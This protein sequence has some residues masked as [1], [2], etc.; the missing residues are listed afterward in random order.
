MERIRARLSRLGL[1]G[2]GAIVAAALIPVFAFAIGGPVFDVNNAGVFEL[3]GNVAHDAATTPP[4]D[5]SDLFT[6][7]GSSIHVANLVNSVFLADPATN[8]FAFISGSSKDGID[9]SN[10]LC[11]VKP[12]PPKDEI[13]NSYAAAFVAPSTSPVAGHVLLYMALE[14]GSINGTSN[15]G[16][17]IFKQPVACDPATGTFINPTTGLKATHSD[18][19]ILL[20]ASFTSGGTTATVRLY[21]WSTALGALVGPTTGQD[22]ATS[23]VNLC[24]ISNAFN[25]ITTPWAPGTVGTNG[26]FEAGIDLTATLPAELQSS[27]FSTFL[28]DTRSSASVTADLHDFISGS[29]SL[30]STPAITTTQSPSTGTVGSTKYSDTAT[31]TGASGSI[32]GETVTFKLFNNATCTGTPAFTTTGTL[33]AGGVASTPLPGF[34]PAAAGTYYWVASYPGDR[35]TGGLNEPATSGCGAEPI[36]VNPV[37]P[38]LTTT[39]T[40]SVSIGS[41]ISDSA[42]L[43]GTVLEPDGVTMAQGSITFTAYNSADCAN[44]ALV[45]T[46][47]AVAVNGNGT[48]PVPPV[49]VS[50]IP[51]KSG[52]Y[53][54][55]AVY[56]STSTNTTGASTKCG[57]SGET[58]TV[59]PVT[60]TTAQSWYPNDSATIGNG[61]G[62]TVTFTLYL[63]DNKCTSNPVFSPPAVTV[64]NGSAATNNTT[65]A[66]TSVKSGDT[67]YW[68]AVYSGDQ[69]H[70]GVS[71]CVESTS[72]SSLA[73][74][75]TVS[76]P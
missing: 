53:Y 59:I 39:A 10:W 45:F 69:T 71:S 75:G 5:W 4:Y 48:Y 16:F 51:T 56:T 30:C 14:R 46:S 76:S 2:V 68:G 41:A 23:V 55:I 57:D 24:G 62:G 19:D 13:Q 40:V 32:A 72:F 43:S 44:T 70:G 42:M 58:S 26:F 20:F 27:C 49:V 9:V 7:S 1:T 34:M 12:V 21:T 50:F 8:D 66:I 73:N 38:T 35:S 36:V 37:T 63:N 64:S 47:S 28:A 22:C 17:W 67:Y 6:S 29:F 25:P 74:G 54:W 65:F 18:G 52:T 60:I 11:T 31:V 33:S 61:G 15:A 3:D